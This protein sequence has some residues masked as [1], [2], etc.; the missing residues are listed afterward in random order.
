MV[1]VSNEECDIVDKFKDVEEGRYFEVV[2]YFA[3][4][5]YALRRS[6]LDEETE[7]D[8]IQSLVQSRPWRTSG[9]KSSAQFSKTLDGRFV[10]KCVSAEEFNMFH[11]QC[12]CGVYFVYMDKTIFQNRYFLCKLR[13]HLNEIM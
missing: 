11:H 10:I 12:A 7:E 8:Y 1:L 4:Q 13:Q 9:G 3:A 2:T 5:F 6:Y